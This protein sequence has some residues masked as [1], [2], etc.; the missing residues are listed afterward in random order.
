MRQVFIPL[1]H[2][3]RDKTPSNG[4]SYQYWTLGVLTQIRL[5][6]KVLTV[7]VSFRGNLSIKEDKLFS[8]CVLDR[9]SE[10]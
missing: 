9:M 1:I 8:E 6:L 4:L 2:D 7:L 3:E 5:L 10:R